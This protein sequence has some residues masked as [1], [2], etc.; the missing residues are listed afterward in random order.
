MAELG[1]GFIT[2]YPVFKSGIQNDI[3]KEYAKSGALAGTTFTNS[4]QRNTAKVSSNLAKVG[5]SAGASFSSSTSSAIAKTSSL[6]ANEGSKAGIGFFSRLKSSVSNIGSHFASIGQQSGSKFAN[7]TSKGAIPG[8]SA[9]GLASGMILYRGIRGALSMVSTA[10]DNAISRVDT[11]RN[12]PKVMQGIGQSA[13]DSKAVIDDL[14]ESLMGLPTTLDQAAQSVQR[15]TATNGDV[16][17][18]SEMFKALNNALIAGASSAELQSSAL[19]QV[20]QAYSKGKMDMIEW[21]SLLQAAPA[22]VA[23]VA[24]HMGKSVDELGAGLR[25]SAGAAEISMDEFMQAIIELNNN[26]TAEFESFSV[27]AQNA[28]G[29]IGVAITNV[30]NRMTK[31]VAAIIEG[32]DKMLTNAGLGTM[33]ENIN[34]LSTN[35][36]KFGEKAGQIIGNIDLK[37]PFTK[38]VV[39]IGVFMVS[40]NSVGWAAKGLSGAFSPLIGIFSKFGN[41]GVLN[42]RK[43]KKEIEVT[44]V[45]AKTMEA[46]SL[47]ALSSLKKGA[48]SLG[49]GVLSAI[50]TPFTKSASVISSVFNYIKTFG[51]TTWATLAYYMG[52]PIYGAVGK[53][54]TAMRGVGKG[55]S[56]VLSPVKT[57][58]SEIGGAFTWAWNNIVVGL[59]MTKEKIGGAVSGILSKV[60]TTLS[61]LSSL[62]SPIF[63]PVG[64]LFSTIFS[65]LPVKIF[66]GVVTALGAVAVA[67]FQSTQT[68]GEGAGSVF[69]GLASIIGSV[70]NTVKDAW[71]KLVT[72]AQPAL[73]GLKT[74]INSLLTAFQPVVDAFATLGGN[75]VNA[76]SGGGGDGGGGAI[77]GIINGIVSAISNLST[78]ISDIANLVSQYMPVILQ[79]LQPIFDLIQNIVTNVLPSLMNLAMTVGSAVMSVIQAAM[80]V[81]TQ[82]I[83]VIMTIWGILSATLIPIITIVINQVMNVIS[84]I[85]DAL[86]PVITAIG[87]VVSAVFGTIGSVIGGIL[88]FVMGIV[89]SVIALFQ[90][91]FEGAFNGLKDTCGNAIQGVIDFFMNL[92]GNILNALGDVGSLLLDAGSKII[93]GLL[94]GIKNAITGVFDFV[95]GIAGKIAELKGPIS[96]DKVL[97]I[98]A[99]KAIV[100]GLYNGLNDNIDT[101]YDLVGGIGENIAESL[102]TEIQTG[103]EKATD[104]SIP[105]S[106]EPVSPSLRAYNESV[107]S[108]DII[109]NNYRINDLKINDSPEI[110]RQFEKLFNMIIKKA[111]MYA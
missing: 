3:S 25:H 57:V 53:I 94:D 44:E 9:L 107:E 37:S 43:V 73:E 108:H 36:Q 33:A 12:F 103:I 6:I 8:M 64:N 40:L 68:E 52:E 62:L 75:I 14:S 88:D 30:R 65:P 18:S 16:K 70:V 41:S 20:T 90:G 10:V 63:A 31:A 87:G 102:D 109:T 84:V 32:I 82:I 85:A 26:G 23:Q 92:P 71:D 93:G 34:K 13:E 100:E 1:T 80:P 98:P 55:L 78:F 28:V 59:N 39:A 38:G 11:L 79:F 35:I 5:S 95:G 99:G 91:D 51:K 45:A 58:A 104:V 72:A 54:S 96:Y 76:L 69:S 111:D 15:F 24:K 77:D 110:A 29:G 48:L 74:A 7:E 101:V 46:S 47:G 56:T 61:P 4:V 66:M 22:Q 89:N 19:E 81:I 50:I 83:T 2:I 17:K 86:S 21:R 42:F 67:V 105:V 27:Q 49:G 60:T 97:L 106:I